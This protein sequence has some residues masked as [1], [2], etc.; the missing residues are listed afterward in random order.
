MMAIETKLTVP[1]WTPPTNPGLQVPLVTPGKSQGQI[2]EGDFP[3]DQI[4][5]DREPPFVLP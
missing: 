1:D 5:I 4:V 2:I 3:L